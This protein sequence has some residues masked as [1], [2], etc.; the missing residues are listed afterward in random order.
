MCTHITPC[1]LH[2]SD[3]NGNLTNTKNQIAMAPAVRG[4]SLGTLFE[5]KAGTAR[6]ERLGEAIVVKE[7]KL[8]GCIHVKNHAWTTEQAA[9]AASV[10]ILLVATKSQGTLVEPAGLFL[11]YDANTPSSEGV[12]DRRPLNTQRA[13]QFL[14]L[15]DRTFNTWDPTLTTSAASYA[16]KGLVVPISITVRPNLPIRFHDAMGTFGSAD[17]TLNC[18]AQVFASPASISSDGINASVYNF[19]GSSTV[20][21]KP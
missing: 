1:A 14:V 11:P 21:F 13:N 3:G 8:T 6:S 19:V 5:C 10:R 7:W 16:T 4:N 20:K 17:V 15:A 12:Y 18:Y 2:P 9:T